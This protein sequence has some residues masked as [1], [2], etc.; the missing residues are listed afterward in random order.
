MCLDV[1]C[2]AEPHVELGVHGGEA[3][4]YMVCRVGDGAV[5]K[6]IGC[7]GEFLVVGGRDF[8]KG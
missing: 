8:F 3:L 7:P 4:C 6:F 5:E 1:H 2:V